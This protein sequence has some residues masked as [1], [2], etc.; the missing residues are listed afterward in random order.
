LT[1][2]QARKVLNSLDGNPLAARWIAALLL[3]MRQGEC[4][5]LRWEDVDFEAGT[6]LVQHELLRITGQGLVLGLPKSKTSLR[7]LPMLAPMAYAMAHTEHRGPFVFYGIAKEPRLDYKAWKE[8]LVRAG[9]CDPGMKLGDMPELAAA[10]TT[11]ATL[12]RDAGVDATVVRDILGHSQVQVTQ[13]SY[14][15]TDAAT[16]RAAIVALEKSVSPA[17]RG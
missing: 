9:V 14:Q 10:R 5:G 16:M 7:T 4:L 2:D 3:G 6:I 11:T 15:R 13:E 17:D 12:L 1:L 8:L